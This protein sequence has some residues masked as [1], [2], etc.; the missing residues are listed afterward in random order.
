VIVAH[1]FYLSADRLDHAKSPSPELVS[2]ALDAGADRNA[3]SVI[4]SELVV[5]R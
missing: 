1:S 2:A 5:Q 3:I 4:P